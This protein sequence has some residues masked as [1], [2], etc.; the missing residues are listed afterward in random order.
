MNIRWK[1]YISSLTPLY[2]LLLIQNLNI[3]NFI[4][5]FKKISQINKFDT[6]YYYIKNLTSNDMFWIVTIIML[7]L[8]IWFSIELFKLVIKE[9][10][11]KPYTY[12]YFFKD[13]FSEKNLDIS[14]VDILNYIFTYLIP[15]LSLDINNFWSILAN[16]FLL[17]LIGFIYTKNNEV[18]FNIVFIIKNINVYTVNSEY[19]IIT[20][21]T[22][23]EILQMNTDIFVT[24]FKT[25]ELTEDIFIVKKNY[26]VPNR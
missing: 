10:G 20:D 6:F 25:Y 9:N 24:E 13:R 7:L 14:N 5:S 1:L 21:L 12:A 19:Q 18:M 11:P 23:K 2:V 15:F 17:L 4:I 3:N 22:K 8:S 26:R 16:I